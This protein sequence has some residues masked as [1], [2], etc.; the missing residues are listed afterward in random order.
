MALPGYPRRGE[1]FGSG[2]AQGLGGALL[3]AL[4]A[5]LK[6]FD[7]QAKTEAAMKKMETS[8]KLF[9]QLF[10]GLVAGG[11]SPTGVP[12]VVPPVEGMPELG[13]GN[14]IPMSLPSG[15]VGVQP[16]A[17]A[18]AQQTLGAAAQ[19][20]GAA[21]QQ[22]FVPRPWWNSKGD[23][24]VQLSPKDNYKVDYSN[25]QVAP[26]LY[27]RIMTITDPARPG[28]MKE[29]VLP[30]DPMP[31]E[32]IQAAQQ[33]AQ[34][35]G[36]TGGAVEA[37]A[38]AL[39][40][41]GQLP[42]AAKAEAIKHIQAMAQQQRQQLAQGGGAAGEQPVGGGAAQGPL[43]D[44]GQAMDAA[45]A[46]K[47]SEAGAV[48]GAAAEAGAAVKA[49][50]APG[51]ASDV[52]AAQQTAK[53]ATVPLS[54][55]NEVRFNLGNS[56]TR[57]L[58]T[59]SK[60][61]KPEYV[62]KGI[63]EFMHQLDAEATNA[64]GDVANGAKFGGLGGAVRA[65]S[66][67]IS[68]EEATFRKAVVNAQNQLLYSLSGQQINEAEYRRL[69]AGLFTLTEEPAVFKAGMS[70]AI[71]EAEQKLKDMLRTHTTPASKLLRQRESGN[72]G[73]GSGLQ[74]LDIQPVQ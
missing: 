67:D 5:V 45:S 33:A 24:G 57:N 68:P 66:G 16:E 11:T 41:A 37:G 52:A 44:V 46:R 18:G 2:F 30:G 51:I 72:G 25:R 42:P 58:K 34:G 54:G 40:A 9:E 28:W 65:F 3:Q 19:P 63:T 53:N 35:F 32:R 74:I 31:G 61:Y 70:A 69:K 23:F 14:Q 47:T 39:M 62:G 15:A 64:E 21:A 38:Q 1:S 59:V 50:T 48:A 4:P 22:Q 13:A 27:R 49:R 10:P 20:A 55:A 6:S 7:D 29:E 12:P 43:L 36:F 71:S 26:G 8:Q 56:L 60:L 73:G 17:V